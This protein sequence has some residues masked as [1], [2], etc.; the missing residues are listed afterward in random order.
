MSPSSKDDSMLMRQ[1][2]I[3][4]K[5]ELKNFENQMR[6]LERALDREKK[7]PYFG[8]ISMRKPIQSMTKMRN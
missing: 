5:S 2:L 6:Q 3:H 1:K 7:T 8:K 4:Y